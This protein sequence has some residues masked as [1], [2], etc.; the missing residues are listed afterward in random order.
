MLLFQKGFIRTK[1]ANYFIRPVEHIQ[2]DTT[3]TIW[4]ELIKIKKIV[5]VNSNND[6][7][8]FD[9]SNIELCQAEGRA[10]EIRH[11]CP[12]SIKN[13]AIAW[14]SVLAITLVA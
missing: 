12:E 14:K 1:D 5:D 11:K 4:H 2:N 6:I 10:S 8:N 13:N 9:A 7:D 3:E